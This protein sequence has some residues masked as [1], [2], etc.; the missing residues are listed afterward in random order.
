MI[1][2]THCTNDRDQSR[3]KIFNFSNFK[4]FRGLFKKRPL[5]K[6]QLNGSIN[7]HTNTVK[8]KSEC[9]ALPGVLL[10]C[11]T[12]LP[13]C[14]MCT[15]TRWHKSQ[16]I[17]IATHH[18]PH[19]I[20]ILQTTEWKNGVPINLENQKIKKTTILFKKTNQNVKLR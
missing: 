2:K 4:V 16:R 10:K 20:K 9:C 13:M 1:K 18:K 3:I 19:I 15:S 8:R 7:T 6:L 17:T 12:P 14:A 5:K 11:R